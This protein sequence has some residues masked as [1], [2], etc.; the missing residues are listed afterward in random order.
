[1]IIGLV[2]LHGAGKSTISAILQDLFGWKWV[3]KMSF[4][5][6]LYDNSGSNLSWKEW[7]G[8]MY[9]QK[10]ACGVM[11]FVLEMTWSPEEMLIVDSVHNKAE[12]TA[13]RE[14]DS[15]AILVGVFA[16]ASVR[17]KRKGDIAE[18][19]KR[20]IG[21]WQENGCLPSCIEWIMNGDGPTESQSNE[22]HLLA[23]YLTTR[24][25]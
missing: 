5:R 19:D 17:A 3:E 13:I 12:W 1:M 21:Y 15:N 25:G 8:E 16:P 18:A 23:N 24:A 2:G 14:V 4:L 10:G 22:C 20:R 9:R 7:C 6:N 11:R